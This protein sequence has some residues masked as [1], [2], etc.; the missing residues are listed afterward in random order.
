[1]GLMVQIQHQVYALHPWIFVS[2]SF[3]DL[4]IYTSSEQVHECGI[5]HTERGLL[6]S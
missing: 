2:N 5:S 3:V 1:M 4:E 6:H